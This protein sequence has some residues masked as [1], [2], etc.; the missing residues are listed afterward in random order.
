M[1]FQPVRR[2]EVRGL[3]PFQGEGV[4]GGGFEGGYTGNGGMLHAEQVLEYRPI[5]E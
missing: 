5:A 3:M 1:L 2:V 4:C